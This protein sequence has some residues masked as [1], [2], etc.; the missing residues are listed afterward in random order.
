MRAQ[1]KPRPNHPE[2]REPAL[3]RAAIIGAALAGAAIALALAPTSAAA[4][5]VNDDGTYVD[6]VVVTPYYYRNGPDRL[7]RVVSIRDLDLTTPSGRE[8]MRLR[9]RDTARDL[10][11]ALNEG[12]GVG[13]LTRSCVDQ[14]IR[15]V[16]PQVRVAVNQAFASRSYAYLDSGYPYDFRAYP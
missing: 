10:C 3:S 16:R 5:A 15:E 1:S 4:Q 14:A 11:R 2:R 7:S 13:G 9:I 12:P 8:V 6:E